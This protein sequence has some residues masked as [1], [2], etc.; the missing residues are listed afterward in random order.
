[1]PTAVKPQEK[2]EER[3]PPL[4]LL[5]PPREFVP[6]AHEKMSY[7]RVSSA[8]IVSF[9]DDC[10][11]NLVQYKAGLAERLEME[12]GSVP[13]LLGSATNL[14]Q[15]SELPLYHCVALLYMVTLLP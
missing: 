6:T 5:C 8:R 9:T 13:T 3:L 7:D 14:E 12:S 1:M 11:L 4:S 2:E 15:V 10:F